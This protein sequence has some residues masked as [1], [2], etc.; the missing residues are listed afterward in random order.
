MLEPMDRHSAT[1]FSN[2]PSTIL[3]AVH[4]PMAVPIFKISDILCFLIRFD[5]LSIFLLKQLIPSDDFSNLIAY[6]YFQLHFG[7]PF[8]HNSQ[9]FHVQYR[10]MSG[11]MISYRSHISGNIKTGAATPVIVI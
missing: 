4:N 10:G 6:I 7:Y 2:A 8:E 3:M 11:H 1:F 5:L 9:F